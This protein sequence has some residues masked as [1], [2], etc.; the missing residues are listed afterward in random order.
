MKLAR[1]AFL[2]VSLCQLLESDA[3]VPVKDPILSPTV[4]HLLPHERIVS[5]GS[6]PSRSGCTPKSAVSQRPSNQKRNGFEHSSWVNFLHEAVTD[7]LIYDW[8][9]RSK[10]SKDSQVEDDGYST[11]KNPLLSLLSKMNPRKTEPGNRVHEHCLFHQL[12][13]QL[14]FRMHAWKAKSTNLGITSF[15]LSGPQAHWFL[16]VTARPPWTTTRLSLDGSTP[17]SQKLE[18]ER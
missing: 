16:F 1:I 3:F 9:F 13:R 2:V 17:I 5:R 11:T 4:C 7:N 18:K 14:L 15:P 10:D 8:L 12:W 6:I